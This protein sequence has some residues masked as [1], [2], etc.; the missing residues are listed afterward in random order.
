MSVSMY[1]VYDNLHIRNAVPGNTPAIQ[2]ASVYH[3][4]SHML[5]RM[6]THACQ[7]SM[8]FFLFHLRQNVDD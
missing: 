5:K 1:L 7:F 8:L 3:P 4:K 2:C 6:V